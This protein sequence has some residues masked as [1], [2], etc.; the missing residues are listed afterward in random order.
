MDGR[1]RDKDIG[2]AN[3]LTTLPQLTSDAGEALHNRAIQGQDIHPVQEILEP[4]FVGC[5][6]PAVV[7]A[8]VDF[9][10]RDQADNK[11]VRAKGGE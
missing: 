9:S 6:V 11:P 7:D 8:F 4:L 10:K 2:V 3:D 5:R 1:R